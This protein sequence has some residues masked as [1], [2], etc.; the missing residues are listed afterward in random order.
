MRSLNNDTLIYEIDF[1]IID[2]LRY[3]MENP[4]DRLRKLALEEEVCKRIL[5]MVTEYMRYHFGFGELK[6]EIFVTG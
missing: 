5:K 2:I 1:G 4:L 3:F 6:S